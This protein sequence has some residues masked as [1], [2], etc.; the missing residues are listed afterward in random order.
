MLNPVMNRSLLAALSFA[1]LAQFAAAQKPSDI[2]L[3][4]D[5]ARLRG[6][7][8]TEFALSGIKAQRAGSAVEVPAHQILSVEWGDLPDAFIAAR[9]A[10]ERGDYTNAV[11]LFG[12]AANTA[13]RELVKHDAEFF[14][15]KAA[16]AS[17]GAD[18]NAARNAADRAKS[19]VGSNATHWRI[20]EALL[21]A[22]RAQR[23]AGA[24]DDAATTLK[25]LD[26][27]ATRE[28]FGAVWSARAKF[29]LAQAQLDGGKSSDARSTFQS[30]SSA[31]DTALGQ[32]SGDD[33][34]LRTIKLLAK[35]GEGETYIGDKDYTK[36]ESF[37]SSL[38]RNDSAEL[39]AAGHAGE[40]EAILLNALAN[41]RTD[42]LRRAQ[43][44]LATAAVVDSGAGEIAAKANYYLGRCV[45]AL[46]QEREGDTFK[47]RAQAYFQIVVSSYPTTRWAGLARAELAK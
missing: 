47:A 42:E 2:V 31:A 5:G 13:K 28:G 43:I 37:F 14:Q 9:A 33:A 12:E 26:D 19:W 29:E 17:I 4:K 30:A 32:A 40:G 18:Q 27:R 39:A 35:V 11:Q 46:G 15:I 16:V 34:E 20:P 1:L 44:A 21:L 23:L 3:K 24:T 6:L 8:I 22:G 41:N 25:D 10:M 38:K 7:E 45:L 36:A